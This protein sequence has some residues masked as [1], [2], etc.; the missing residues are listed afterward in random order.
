MLVQ[1][2]RL[3]QLV[4]ISSQELWDTNPMTAG[5][6]S[7]LKPGR[8]IMP[9]N[10]G[11]QE[12]QQQVYYQYARLLMYWKGE[13]NLVSLEI[14]FIDS[15][16]AQALWLSEHPEDFDW[17][18][19]REK[20]QYGLLSYILMCQEQYGWGGFS[21]N[22]KKALKVMTMKSLL[23]ID[24][25]PIA[26]GEEADH[27]YTIKDKEEVY[28]LLEARV[29]T[30][31]EELWKVYETPSGG[32]H[33]FLLSHHYTPEEGYNLLTEMKGDTLYRDI[34][35]KRGEWA[36]RIGPKQGRENDFV[37]RYVGS[38]GSGKAL[39]E[40]V[41]TISVHDSFLPQ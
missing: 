7:I 11:T 12:W 36:V 21:Y 41:E 13:G 34:S 35:L 26:P 23:M 30:H 22:W 15:L 8:I 16:E 3:A 29:S 18:E 31:L 39:P 10:D 20:N 40:H 32:I 1:Q 5:K 38:F 24:W 25:D 17:I 4:T 33:A 9:P 6:K 28:E 19:Q 27:H 37:A 2:F 14:P